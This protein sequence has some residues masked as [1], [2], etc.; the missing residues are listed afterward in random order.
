M[1]GKTGTAQV[2]GIA[3]DEEYDAEKIAKRKRDHALFVG[4]APAEKPLI[5]VAV[6][7]ENGEHGSS[8][9]APVARK[10]MD[11]YLLPLFERIKAEQIKAK[12]IKEQQMQQ[13]RD[14][15][16]HIHA[17]SLPANAA[18]NGNVLQERG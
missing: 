17:E 1:A 9:A 13:T 6:V 2:I 4:F 16:A 11:A 7:V 18:A 5:A 12:K 14:D 15:T 10:V 8:A 3:Q